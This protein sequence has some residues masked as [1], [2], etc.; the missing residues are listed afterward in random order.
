[1]IEAPPFLTYEQ[2]LAFHQV[3]LELYGGQSGLRD[4]GLLY[5]ALAQPEAGLED[6]YYHSY[7][8]GMAAAY[9]F[10]IAENQPFIDGNKRVA[11]DCCLTFLELCGIAVDDPDGQL[12][13]AMIAIGTR[14]LTKDGFAT[15]LERLAVATEQGEEEK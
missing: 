4:E 7:P 13:D 12:F 6:E 14:N 9:A 2:V 10:H 1:V 8:Y 5:S 11:L 15:L 3:Q